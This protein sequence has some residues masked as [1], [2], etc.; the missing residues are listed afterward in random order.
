MGTYL[1]PDIEGSTKLARQY[2]DASEAAWQRHHD[3]LQAA[4]WESIL[5]DI[6][7]KNL[8][9]QKPI[10]PIFDEPAMVH[11]TPRSG[12][13]VIAPGSQCPNN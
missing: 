10:H 9:T 12:G 3:I 11:I 4:M 2:P 5:N 7:F 8:V 13:F 1:F 6:I